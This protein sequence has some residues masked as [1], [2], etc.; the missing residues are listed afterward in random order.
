V[1][2]TVSAPTETGITGGNRISGGFPPDAVWPQV[3]E[4]GSTSPVAATKLATE[5]TSL[6]WNRTGLSA[7]QTRCYWLRSVSAEGDLA[8]LAGQPPP[9]HSYGCPASSPIGG[10]P[11]REP[12]RERI[13][14]SWLQWESRI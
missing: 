2:T 5:P 6:F 11:Q 3:F 10:S 7:G 1:L 8:A 14:A 4:A 12:W 13:V 9:P